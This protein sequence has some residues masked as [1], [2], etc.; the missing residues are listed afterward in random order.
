MISG[1][2]F[3][4]H[5]PTA[6]TLRAAALVCHVSV[7]SPLSCF[8]SVFSLSLSHHTYLCL[9]QKSSGYDFLITYLSVPLR[10]HQG[11]ISFSS[12]ISLSLPLITDISVSLRNPQCTISFSSHVSLSLSVLISVLFVGRG[13]LE[14]CGAMN[15]HSRFQ[16]NSMSALTPFPRALRDNL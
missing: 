5:F 2:A 6:A 14:G 7:A 3:D 8:S 11:T 9:S 4:V 1:S 10:P 13:K 15:T 16:F 12:H